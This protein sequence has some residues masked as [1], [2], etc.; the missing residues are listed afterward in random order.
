MPKLPDASDLSGVNIGAP[1]SLVGMPAPDIAGAANTIA[2]GVSDLGQ[3]ITVVADERRKKASAQERFDT[4]MALL[5]ADED[6]YNQYKDLDRLDPEF[7]QKARALRIQTHGPILSSVKDPDNRM[8]YDLATE[9]DFVRIGIEADKEHT[10]AR[11]KKQALDFDDYFD[12][13]RKGVRNKT[14]S[15]D[16]VA[17]VTQMIEDMDI[18]PLV[19]QELLPKVLGVLNGDKFE[20]EFETIVSGGISVTPSVQSAVTRA[21]ATAGPDAPS[22]LG[23]YLL[24]VAMME[25]DGGRRKVNP[26]NPE[27]LGTWQIHSNTAPGLRLAL[28]DRADD[29]K[30][31]VAMVE[32]TMSNYRML[33]KKLGREPTPAELYLPHQQGIGGAPDLLANPDKRAVDVVKRKAVEQNLTEDLRH[34][35]DT[36][37]AKQFADY[38]MAK[39]EGKTGGMVDPKKT[40]ETLRSTESY[41]NMSADEQAKADETVLKRID[42]QNAE[43]KKS[44]DINTARDAANYAAGSFETIAEAYQWIDQNVADPETREKARTMAK[45]EFEANEKSREAAYEDTLNKAYAGVT[46]ALKSDDIGAALAAIPYDGTLNAKDVEDL[47]KRVKEGKIQFD[48]PRDVERINDLKYSRDPED[49]KAFARLD[50]NRFRLSDATRE[51]VFKEQQSIAKEFEQTGSAPSLAEPSKM[52]NDRVKEMGIEDNPR[53]VRQIKTILDQNL[54]IATDRVGRKLMPDELQRVFDETLLEFSRT[55]TVDQLGGLWSKEV[56]AGDLPSI[57]AEFDAVTPIANEQRAANKQ[58]PLAPGELL[59][60]AIDERTREHEDAKAF[61]AEQMRALMSRAR[62][63]QARMQGNL[64]AE[65]A[66]L[67]RAQQELDAFRIDAEDLYLWLARTFKKEEE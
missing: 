64:E 33:K 43:T 39:F 37:T 48:D 24:R 53:L 7:P 55:K 28:G 32:F 25:S 19:K 15:G 13:V 16:P 9:E 41:Q 66:K 18:D 21:V 45:S 54:K 56:P 57:I 65:Y 50:L 58:P 14:Y 12:G 8:K 44:A 34:L 2:R 67:Q 17:D 46:N 5:K 59:Q 30:S 29:E 62:S 11:Q 61:V 20:T 60:I 31:A 47:E 52:L 4:S 26:E 38:V 3:G 51:K 42:K 10:T 22:Y 27:V 1:R 6:F 63:P 36:I 35:T 40:L 23:D 49:Q